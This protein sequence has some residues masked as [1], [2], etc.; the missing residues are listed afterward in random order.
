MKGRREDRPTARPAR[1]AIGSLGEIMIAAGLMA[2]VAR[3]GGEGRAPAATVAAPKPPDADP[4]PKSPATSRA[5]TAGRPAEPVATPAPAKASPRPSVAASS[6]ATSR[7]KDRHAPSQARPKAKARAKIAV[8]DRMPPLRG[9]AA[10]IATPTAPPANPGASGAQGASIE[11][12][13]VLIERRVSGLGAAF[14]R[15]E[16]IA[17]RAV[18]VEEPDAAALRRRLAAACGPAGDGPEV[19]IVLGVDFGTTSTKVVA[20]RPYFAGSPAAAM[21]APAFARPEPNPHLWASRL[22]RT[23]DGRLTL[24]PEAEAA[25]IC[26]IKTRLMEGDGP[27]V[28]AHAAAFLGQIVAHAR[29][30]LIGE[31]PDFVGDRRPDWRHHFG[32]PAASLE[33]AALAGRYRRVVAAALR[34]AA[35]G[36]APTEEEARAAVAAATPSAAEAVEAGALLFPEV[37]GATAAFVA[38]GALAGRLHVMVDVGGGTVD[39]CA[40][41]LHSPAPGETIQPIFRAAVDM[42]G[43]EPWRLCE[44][45]PR[46]E[47]AFGVCLATH[48]KE[49]IWST[50]QGHAPFSHCWTEG[51]PVLL[52]GGGAASRSHARQVGALG[53]WL[54][55]RNCPGGIDLR[56]ATPPTAFDHAAGAEGGHRLTVALGLSLPDTEIPQVLQH[57]EP[58]VGFRRVDTTDRYVGPEQT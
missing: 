46:A 20:R 13:R 55:R 33:D 19:E 51:L 18:A 44:G 40:F 17:A 23:R 9:G 27:D 42:L 56:T 38:S 12:R 3:S 31:R 6:L 8:P 11:D 35:F 50:K 45:D 26:A 25:P 15:R 43:V 14:A 34:I 30:W 7:P 53:P 58:F 2:G 21:P 16:A 41:N 24:A 32:F 57:I 49:V 22:W 48:L 36:R 29:G 1:G 10:A 47:E 5:P 54:R 37:A 28:E 39:V 4:P 52:I